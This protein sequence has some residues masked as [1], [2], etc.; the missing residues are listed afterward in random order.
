VA[1]KLG[2]KWL[3]VE[4]GGHFYTVILPRMKKVLSYDKKGISKEKDLKEK[5]NPKDAGG[6]F[7]Y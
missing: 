7:K 1:H 2:R 3:G 4:I 6:F 5:Y